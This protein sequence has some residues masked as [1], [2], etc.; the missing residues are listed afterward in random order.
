M[1]HYIGYI[2]IA[3]IAFLLTACE[4]TELE[5]GDEGPV[6]ASTGSG[7]EPV[8]PGADNEWPDES[9]PEVEPDAPDRRGIRPSA[10]RWA[11]ER[12]IDRLGQS[13]LRTFELRIGSDLTC[14]ERTLQLEGPNQTHASLEREIIDGCWQSHIIRV[15][16]NRVLKKVVEDHLTGAQ[17]QSLLEVHEQAELDAIRMAIVAKLG[18][19]H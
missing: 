16:E 2:A 15:L 9:M 14:V 11:Q 17:A 10:Y 8:V 5:N 4:R 12:G 3:A 1:I 6:E 13:D 7:F 19:E 18:P